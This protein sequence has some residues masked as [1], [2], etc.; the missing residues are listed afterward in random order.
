M[1]KNIAELLHISS[2]EDEEHDGDQKCAQQQNNQL[3]EGPCSGRKEGVQVN[4]L[5]G[6]KGD[7]YSV[8]QN[9]MVGDI[10]TTDY[11]YPSESALNQK[12]NQEQTIFNLE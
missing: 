6:F 5:K 3:L 2:D 7:L 12:G 10:H 1:R 4:R 11:V 8:T 9:H